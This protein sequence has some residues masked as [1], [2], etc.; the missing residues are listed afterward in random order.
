MEEEVRADLKGIFLRYRQ[1]RKLPTDSELDSL[2]SELGEADPVHPP[3]DLRVQRLKQFV[4][5]LSQ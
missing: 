1:T 3:A 2:K 4:A 5:N